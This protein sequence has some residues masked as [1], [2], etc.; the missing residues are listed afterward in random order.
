MFM[1]YCYN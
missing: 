1:Q